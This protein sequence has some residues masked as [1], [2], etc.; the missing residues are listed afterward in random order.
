MAREDRIPEQELAER[1][2][3]G[4]ERIVRRR[5]HALGQCREGILSL[6]LAL[7]GREEQ[8][9]SGHQTAGDNGVSLPHSSQTLSLPP[10]RLKRGTAPKRPDHRDLSDAAVEEIARFRKRARAATSCCIAALNVKLPSFL[11]LRSTNVTCDYFARRGGVSDNLGLLAGNQPA[12]LQVTVTEFAVESGA[13]RFFAGALAGANNMTVAVKVMG[14]QGDTIA[15]FDVVRS[16]NPGGYSAF[17]DQKAATI[18]SV[19]DGV[20]EVMSGMLK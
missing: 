13:T 19:A 1:H 3:V 17:Y 2:L 8:Q 5:I 11:I 12:K 10:W 6:S 14:A 7:G 16:S 18:N 9:H 15:D 4:G 20:T